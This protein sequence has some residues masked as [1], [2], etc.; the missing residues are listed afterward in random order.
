MTK[1]LA[2]SEIGFVC[3][4]NCGANSLRRSVDS[5]NVWSVYDSTGFLFCFHLFGLEE[6]AQLRIP[7]LKR[8]SREMYYTP[9]KVENLR[10]IFLDR[11]NYA[12]SARATRAKYDAIRHAEKTAES[13]FVAGCTQH[14]RVFGPLESRGPGRQVVL[15]SFGVDND[16]CDATFEYRITADGVNYRDQFS[17]MFHVRSPEAA[18]AHVSAL[19]T[20]LVNLRAAGYRS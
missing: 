14:F 12:R 17:A 19:D 8:P 20:L 15:R 6:N 18:A 4:A 16:Q 10:R 11:I 9:G 13:A 1:T 2:I 3:A 5:S 7:Q